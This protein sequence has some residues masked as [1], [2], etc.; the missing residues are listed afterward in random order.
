MIIYLGSEN[1]QKVNAVFRAMRKMQVSDLRIGAFPTDSGVNPQ[2][3]GFD[4]GQRGAY[5]RAR[6]VRQLDNTA[7]ALGIESFI[8]KVNGIILDI[9]ALHL[10]MPDGTNHIGTSA[11]LEMPAWAYHEAKQRG[12]DKCTIG[13]VIAERNGGSAHD[14]HSIVTSR[15][16]SRQF[17]LSQALV[18]IFTIANIKTST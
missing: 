4:E 5:N 15:Q 3:I 10:I 7:L 16:L 18:N 14:P 12:F 2:P 13:Q 6:V 8:V 17:I 1:S 11:S 9:A